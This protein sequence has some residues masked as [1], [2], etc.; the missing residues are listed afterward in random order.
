MAMVRRSALS[1]ITGAIILLA[2]K[3]CSWENALALGL[4]LIAILLIIVTSDSS[5][6][7][8]YQGF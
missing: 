3:V 6:A 1:K 8:I 5:P 4:S 2:S 7:W